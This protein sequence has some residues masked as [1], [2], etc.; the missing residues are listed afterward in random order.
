MR[1]TGT[2][3]AESGGGSAIKPVITKKTV[4]GILRQSRPSGKGEN[5]S[6]A[7]CPQSEND[8]ENS[9]DIEWFEDVISEEETTSDLKS[10]T[11]KSNARPITYEFDW[12]KD[13][14]DTNGNSVPLL[15]GY[16]Y[17]LSLR[18]KVNNVQLIVKKKD[19]TPWDIDVTYGGSSN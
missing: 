13:V 4:Y 15:H 16:V 7:S 18:L 2:Y 10:L 17:E 11:T 14:K 12:S 1:I 5:W 6:N 9:N 19:W 3:S 8:I